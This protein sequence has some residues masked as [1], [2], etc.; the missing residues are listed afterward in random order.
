MPDTRTLILRALLLTLTACVGGCVVNTPVIS[1]LQLSAGDTA[2]A[3]A[4]AP[5]ILVDTVLVPDFLL[6]DELLLRDDAFTIRYDNTRRWAEPI[7]IGV[8]RVIALRLKS[9]LHTRQ[10]NRFPDVPR[11]QQDYWILQIEIRNF[12]ARG[13][14]ALLNASGRWTL[15]TRKR[16]MDKAA[17]KDATDHSEVVEFAQ[18][19][20]LRDQSGP[21]I[22][23]A[24]STL[25][26]HFADAL[27]APIKSAE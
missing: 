18:S 7:D 24:M 12:D 19:L 10:V 5:V 16:A 6:R 17:D 3:S 21:A 15:N 25:L 9:A 11:G 1:H 20:P 4:D 27:A 23:E 14:T 13:N 8:Q 2:P 26:W 22:A